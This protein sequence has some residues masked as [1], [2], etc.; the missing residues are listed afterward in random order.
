MRPKTIL[1]KPQ[2]ETVDHKYCETYHC[3]AQVGQI[4]ADV[5]HNRSSVFPFR[6]SCLSLSRASG[7]DTAHDT[8]VQSVV[9]QRLRDAS[10]T[11]ELV[12]RAPGM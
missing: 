11:Q 10:G 6:V 1:N 2:K 12:N 3:T 5:I 7:H 4:V 8:A 9:Q